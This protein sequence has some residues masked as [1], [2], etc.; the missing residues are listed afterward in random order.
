MERRSL[1]GRRRARA[2]DY[3][4]DEQTPRCSVRTLALVAFGAVVGCAGTS[5]F[6]TTAPR[7]DR[8]VP[9]D[10]LAVRDAL[11]A[12]S[13][14]IVATSAMPT[15]AEIGPEAAALRLAQAP[16]A[17][18]PHISWPARDVGPFDLDSLDG[19][20]R[21]VRGRASGAENE[22]VL[23][24][25]NEYGLPAA[26]NLALQLHR[27]GI[28]HHLVLAESRRTCEV[29]QARWAWMGCGWSVGL[30]GF[31]ERYGDTPRVRLWG[32]CPPQGKLSFQENRFL[33]HT[34]HAVFDRTHGLRA[35]LVAAR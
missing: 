2:F 29:A 26:A 10:A 15:V 1:L 23:F 3:E 18:K 32:A 27:L 9:A 14:R 25:S 21:A 35:L 12:R 20:R 22:L 16:A 17:S 13:P 31:V 6:S 7:D 30:P 11:P 34:V 19:L 5:A 28:Y 24:T 33:A 4:D 8:P